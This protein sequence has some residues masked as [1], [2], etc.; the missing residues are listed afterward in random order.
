MPAR[1]EET[2]LEAVSKV[3]VDRLAEGF[4][5]PSSCLIRHPHLAADIDPMRFDGGVRLV[6]DDLAGEL[7]LAAALLPAVAFVEEMACQRS[8]ALD[9]DSWSGVLVDSR[10]GHEHNSGHRLGSVASTDSFSYQGSRIA[11]PRVVISLEYPDLAGT[12]RLPIVPQL[13]RPGA[14]SSFCWGSCDWDC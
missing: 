1:A 7:L 8:D 14:S 6:E 9:E 4:S 3:H 10:W 2:V 11:C 13:R 12:P 5:D